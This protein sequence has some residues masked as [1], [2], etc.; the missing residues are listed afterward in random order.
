MVESRSTRQKRILNEAIAA[1]SMLFSAQALYEKALES[2][3]KISLATV[4]RHLKR[5]EEDR[6]I[7][8]YQCDGHKVYSV[9]ARTHC[10]YT[11]TDTGRQF[12]FELP[13]I[14][15]LTDHVPGTIE[16]VRI[17]V[18]G[19]CDTTCGACGK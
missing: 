10:H 18:T 15:F 14:D 8:A 17:E 12:H 5:R 13:Q 11:C 3:Q 4:Y 9:H 16:S 7:Y 6:S 19:R 1:F 2:D